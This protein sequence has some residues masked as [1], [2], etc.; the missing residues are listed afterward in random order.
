MSFRITPESSAPC[1]QAVVS[2]RPMLV[3]EMLAI[4]GIHPTSAQEGMRRWIQCVC[5]PGFTTLLGLVWI[6]DLW[7]SVY[8]APVGIKPKGRALMAEPT[9]ASEEHKENKSV[10]WASIHSQHLQNTGCTQILLNGITIY[11]KTTF[12]IIEIIEKKFLKS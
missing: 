4:Y 9:F 3:W 2:P 6:T 5:A 8:K 7:V 10:S 12:Y 11:I 1:F